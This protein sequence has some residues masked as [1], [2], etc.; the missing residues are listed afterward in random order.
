MR[1][2]ESAPVRGGACL[3]SEGDG[4]D[5][6][7]GA[8]VAQSRSRGTTVTGRLGTFSTLKTNTSKGRERA[9]NI[10]SFDLNG[11]RSPKSGE[12]ATGKIWFKIGRQRT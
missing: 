9:G 1:V 7:G 2:G 10:L 12:I 5:W 8:L 4:W 6:P 3:R 11:T